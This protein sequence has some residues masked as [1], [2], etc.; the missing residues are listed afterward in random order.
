VFT[1]KSEEF[2]TLARYRYCFVN[3]LNLGVGAGLWQAY[4]S[5]GFN[6]AFCF[7]PKTVPISFAAFSYKVVII[8]LYIFKRPALIMAANCVLS[9]VQPE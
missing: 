8:S 4:G 5:S 1:E 9:E 3:T 7:Y 6:V 2:F